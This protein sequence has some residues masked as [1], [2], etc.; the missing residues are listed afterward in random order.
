MYVM[1][2]KYAT[3]PEQYI[4]A[5]SII[6]KDLLELFDYVEPSDTNLPCYS[7]RVHELHMRISIE[8][9]ANCKAILSE[10]G[11]VRDGDRNMGDY[12]KLNPT[13]QLS[14]YE[15]R[16]PLW[17][18]TKGTR[19]P[20]AAWATGGQLPWYQAY[21]EAKHDRHNKFQLANFEHLVDAVCGLVTILSAQFWIH[22]FLPSV[23]GSSIGRPSDGFDVAI[24]SYFH[25]K[26]PTNW[27]AADRYSFNWQTL[28][29]DPE[30]FQTLTF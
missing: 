8:V 19:T 5:F 1:H 4:R 20:F 3:A 16:I 17:H 23:I 21:N 26:F 10:N 15:I 9:E 22:D 24:G 11:Y 27:P 28:E 30:P 18:G 29:N 6:Q 13:H 14:A 2:P 7:Y 12:K 25:I